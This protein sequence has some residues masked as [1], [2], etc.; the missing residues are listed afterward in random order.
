M[1][2]EM[3]SL[4]VKVRFV[5]ETAQMEKDLSAAVARGVSGSSSGSA[6][7]GWS[8][9][10]ITLPPGM[11]QN[12]KALT[13]A[14]EGQAKR[15][16]ASASK[17]VKDKAAYIKTDNALSK[18]LV[19]GED[20]E[21][22]RREQNAER[23]AKV[24]D[25][26]SRM[27]EKRRKRAEK[28][29]ALLRRNGAAAGKTGRGYGS[30][31]MF[32]AG[33]SPIMQGLAWQSL[34]MSSP[35]LGPLSF[36][37][38]A[39]MQNFSIRR[40]RRNRGFN[41][42][43]GTA[44][45]QDAGGEQWLSAAHAME[46]INKSKLSEEK[47]EGHRKTIDIMAA[48]RVRGGLARK[49]DAWE[50]GVGPASSVGRAVGAIGGLGTVALGAG[51]ALAAAAKMFVT[52]AE[53]TKES[54]VRV[55][56]TAVTRARELEEANRSHA[57]GS[58][59][60]MLGKE[61]SDLALLASVG[62][63]AGPGGKT[64]EYASLLRQGASKEQATEIMGTILNASARGAGSAEE[65]TQAVVSSGMVG[66]A[67]PQRIANMLPKLLGLSMQGQRA[68]KARMEGGGG[69]NTPTLAAIVGS[70]N[71]ETVAS[72]RENQAAIDAAPAGARIRKQNSLSPTEELKRGYRN[73][74][75]DK[76]EILKRQ[77]EASN[78]LVELWS[79]VI[80]LFSSVRSATRTYADTLDE[81]VRAN[82]EVRIA[83][84]N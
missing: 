10:K 64:A 25:L 72:G 80:G 60:K 8:L 40:Q 7:A 55:A 47:K 58:H 74:D 12:I 32:A 37:P 44:L 82:A 69:I 17:I 11:L 33:T 3:T 20:W 73:A 35:L 68:Y 36:A 66:R 77:M 71:A 78:T 13:D 28:E 46:A 50:S 38:M 53:K 4:P 62:A 30:E 83:Q 75:A 42:G 9:P 21:L 48:G 24:D 41:T 26:L 1:S 15:A 39:M 2:D 16:N 52:A 63:N 5:A 56:S 49:V 67:S 6:P 54:A 61:G 45:S 81:E 29:Q 43:P 84:G 31:G 51:M 22:T 57:L 18:M 34:F 23:A 79:E 27:S 19:A 76:N 14:L 59:G 70:M 65:L